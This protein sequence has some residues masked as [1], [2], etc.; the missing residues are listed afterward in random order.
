PFHHLLNS[1]SKREVPMDPLVHRLTCALIAAALAVPASGQ[2]VQREGG[3]GGALPRPVRQVPTPTGTVYIRCG[4]LL[5]G[6][7]DHPR[8][9][10]V[11]TVEGER[12]KQLGP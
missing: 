3:L 10:I 5:D 12:I 11:I 4:T 6:K 8:A 9:N 2:N 1:R 7:S